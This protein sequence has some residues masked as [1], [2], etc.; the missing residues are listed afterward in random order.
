[1]NI[2]SRLGRSTIHSI[3]TVGYMG[4][5]LGESVYWLLVGAWKGQKVSLG[6]VFAE[7]MEI[8]V[9]AVPIVFIL[10]LTVGVMLAIQTIVTL[11]IFGAESQVIMAIAISVTREFGPLITGILVAGRTASALA[12]RVGS[13]VVSEEV[14]ALVVIGVAPVRYLVAPP[15]LALM[16]MLPILTIIADLAGI[17][18]GALYSSGQLDMT[19]KAYMLMSVDILGVED[20]SQ[21]LIKSFVFGLLIALVGVTAG[22]SVRGGAEGVGKST[23]IAVVVSISMIV[24]ADMIFT[25]FLSR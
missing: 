19:L 16:V 24:V 17:F 2:I 8:G 3:E 11:K 9:R 13:M 18:G 21:G 22:F 5:L 15:L 20:I 12:A 4:S 7:M 14:D 1:M 23:T 25:Y 6:S 10:S